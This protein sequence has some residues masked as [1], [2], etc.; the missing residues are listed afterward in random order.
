MGD[1]S[2]S[3]A[4]G[5]RAGVRRFA[6]A[7]FERVF[8]VEPTRDVVS[9]E[10]LVAGLRR[11]LVK[12]E[13]RDHPNPKQ[14]LRLWS[15][16]HYPAGA[17]R[18]SENVVHLS[19]LVLD[20]DSGVPVE[21]ASATWEEYFHLIHSTWSH[22]PGH[23]KFRL[24]LPLAEPVRPADWPRV[25]G[26]AQER[27]GDR[28]DPTGKSVGTTFAL[29]AV[30]DAAMPRLALSRPGPLLDARVEGLVDEPADPPP[31]PSSEEAQPDAPNHF[32]I[33]IPG[34][35]TV[36]GSLGWPAADDA[37]AADDGDDPWES[38][39]FPWD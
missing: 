4:N 7:T 1:S 2:R 38:A 16:A 34:N 20:Y 5:G 11:F 17:R 22:R 27:T 30:A 23:P 37:A 9:L 35:E 25:Y 32:R 18:G 6:V 14:D 21:E 28:V 31:G 10:R 33:P 19:C 24:V 36:E 3:Q 8:D 26:W 12:P 15:P 13:T 39:S 29:P